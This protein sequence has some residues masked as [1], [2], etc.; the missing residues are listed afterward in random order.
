MEY[1]GLKGLNKTLTGVDFKKIL[2]QFI[3]DKQKEDLDRFDSL[4]IEFLNRYSNS[5]LSYKDNLSKILL[6]FVEICKLE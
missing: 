3:K 2:S 5:S 6:F 4:L 1:Y